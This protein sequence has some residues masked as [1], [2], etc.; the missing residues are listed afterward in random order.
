[1]QILV[2]VKRPTTLSMM[3]LGLDLSLKHRFFKRAETW[4]SDIEKSIV[5]GN[6]NDLMISGWQYL[7]R[8][9]KGLIATYIIAV[10]E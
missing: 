9:E 2:G 1:M 8:R 7:P 4:Q 3:V 5:I 10:V 6:M